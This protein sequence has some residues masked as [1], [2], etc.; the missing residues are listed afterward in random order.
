MPHE[1]DTLVEGSRGVRTL[2]SAMAGHCHGY[3]DAG[4]PGMAAT[5]AATVDRMSSEIGP[6][7]DRA[8]IRATAGRGHEPPTG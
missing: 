6:R 5:L 2:A 7:L 8:R 1:R 4:H 3:G